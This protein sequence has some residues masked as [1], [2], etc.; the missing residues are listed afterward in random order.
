MTRLTCEGSALDTTKNASNE[1][2]IEQKMKK[3]RKG[4][5]CVCRCF[6]VWVF[7]VV[8]SPSSLLD[9]PW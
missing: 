6:C 4:K 7:V 1:K 8:Y 5:M 3:N 9:K 2:Q